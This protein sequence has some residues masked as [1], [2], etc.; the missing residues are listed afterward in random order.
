MFKF[1]KL[2]FAI[3]MV[4][5][6]VSCGSD[7]DN[8]SFENNI[9]DDNIS[10]IL[11]ENLEKNQTSS[12]IEKIEEN[13]TQD[14]NKKEV[15]ILKGKAIDGYIAGAKVVYKGYET[16][17]DEN[18]DWVIEINN[19]KNIDEVGVVTISGGTDIV[20]QKPFQGILSNIVEKDDF[21]TVQY[22]NGETTQVLESENKIFV[23]PIT[24]LVVASVKNG[25]SV[26][27]AKLTV[28]D[29]LGL[30]VDLL[31]KDPIA[32]LDSNN[33]EAK[34]QA[35]EYIKQALI[36]QKTTEAL[37]QE[38]ADENNSQEAFQS[39]SSVLANRIAEQNISEILN[40]PTQLSED[41]SEK[42]D[43]N[44]TLDKSVSTALNIIETLDK[45]NIEK[46]DNSELEKVSQEIEITF[47]DFKYKEK[48]VNQTEE[49]IDENISKVTE[50]IIEDSNNTS[51]DNQTENMEDVENQ[52]NDEVQDNNIQNITDINVN[53]TQEN[54][55]TSSLPKIAS[56]KSNKIYFI[57]Q[58][59]QIKE[60]N[61]TN[62]VFE[63]ILYSDITFNNDLSQVALDIET[64]NIAENDEVK[65][66]LGVKI[67]NTDS[68]AT[69]IALIPD[70]NLIYQDNQL[71]IKDESLARKLYVYGIKSDNTALSTSIV[72]DIQYLTIE[73]N[74][75]IIEYQAIFNSISSSD[76]AN[77][78][79][80]TVDNYLNSN[81]KYQLDIYISGFEEFKG[82]QTINSNQLINK[83][84]K[85][86]YI[87]N[88]T[89]KFSEK[90]FGISG[91]IITSKEIQLTIEPA[92]Q[93]PSSQ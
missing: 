75:L 11:E 9:T 43:K 89:T 47:E 87:S 20:T 10:N 84:E 13:Q 76:D 36:I 62:G 77:I 17:S 16:I 19:S 68:P 50:E 22:L 23:T 7:S 26:E 30:N 33:S 27:Q 18:G 38:V 59:N 2:I 91:N 34:K 44:I 80:E 3:L 32:E 81:G 93:T 73:E 88:I 15:A 65:I 51:D 57:N 25:L 21:E 52:I 72:K 64:Q 49:K 90:I 5:I 14:S 63:D 83:F 78:N 86:D 67:S 45:I 71:K 8:N 1:R 37:T 85:T 4:F 40:N 79:Q 24:T 70:I 46:F 48:E 82:L 60:I 92:P 29:S 28:A 39:I 6:F 53:T 69:I 56:L 61:L 41:I 74:K 35:S 55:E 42:L 66:S 12:P 58:I 31:E 54:Q